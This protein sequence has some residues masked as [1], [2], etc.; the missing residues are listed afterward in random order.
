MPKML[1]CKDMTKL[2]SDSLDGKISV[3]QRME[4]WLHILMCDMCRLFRSNIIELRKRVRGSK[5]LLEQS[6]TD[7]STMPLATQARLEEAIK[8]QLG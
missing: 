4:L 7:A 8:R 5:A 6:E 1:N 2:I 3:R